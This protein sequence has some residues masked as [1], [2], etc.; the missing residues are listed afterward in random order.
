MEKEFVRN[1]HTLNKVN[2]KVK[3]LAHFKGSLPRYESLYASGFDVRAQLS[4]KVLLKPI[5][6]ALIPT[7]LC[8]E[9]PL[10]FELQVRPRSGLS[11]KKGLSIPNSPGTIDA[12]YR[13]ELK[14]IM[15]NYSEEIVP[16]EDQQR[17]AQVVLCPVVQ[18]GFIEVNELN[19]TSRGS[20]G[21]GST[22]V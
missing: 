19:N 11:F 3:R 5:H 4:E 20:G 21:F 12:D 13:G 15:I 7:G 10:G 8:F 14:I 16:I 22:G 1:T 6:R 9:L 17:I 2:I 18:A